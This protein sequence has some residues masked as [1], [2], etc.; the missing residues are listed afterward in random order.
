MHKCPHCE[1]TFFSLEDLM[2]H[3]VHHPFCRTVALSEAIMRGADIR[4]VSMIMDTASGI[5]RG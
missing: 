5:V 2:K 3:F 4:T 1:L